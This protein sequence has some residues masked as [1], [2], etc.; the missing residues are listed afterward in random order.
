MKHLWYI[1]NINKRLNI[2]NVLNLLKKIEEM[3][4]NKSN[5]SKKSLGNIFNLITKNDNK[6]NLEKEQSLNI[7]NSELPI[8]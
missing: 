4:I 7:D 2:I 3:K 1:E 8:N 5:Y 6:K